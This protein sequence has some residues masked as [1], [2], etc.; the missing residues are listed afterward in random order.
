M[1]YSTTGDPTRGVSRLHI[2]QVY[3]I[4]IGLVAMVVTLTFDYRTFTD[5]SHFIYHRAAR[6]VDLRHVLR[7]RAD[8]RAPVDHGRRLQPAA[9]RV[10]KNRRRARPRQILRRKPRHAGVERSRHRRRAH[11]HSVRADRQGAGPRHGGDAAAGLSRGGVS[12]RDADARV[13]RS[14]RSCMLLA[15][16][17]AWKFALKDYQ[18]S[19]IS[20]FL[21]PSQDAKGAGYQQI[22]ARITVGSGGLTG[23]GFRQRDAG[24]A[25][26]P[27]GRPQRFHLLGAGRGAGVCRRPG[28]ARPVFIRDSARAR[29]G[30]PGSK[31]GSA[32][33][34]CSACSPASP[35]RWFT[36]SPCR[37]DWRPSKG[38]R[39]RS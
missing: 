6:A 15:A 28:G 13:R 8:G 21:D 31:T 29:G 4:V 9:V 12:R 1:I 16:P 20:T 25:S 27:A 7:R 18:K 22:Q 14:S 24:T 32:R 38:S 11:T 34:S 36:T 17:I 10:R 5:K 37:P 23:K 30:P 33:T 35:S 3:A 39:C 19:R 2:T 26:V